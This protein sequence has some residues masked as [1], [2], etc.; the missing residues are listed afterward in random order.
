MSWQA[1][2]LTLTVI[3]T[4]TLTLTLTL[5]LTLTLTLTQHRTLIS[6]QSES[7]VSQAYP[8]TRID[9]V[10]ACP[11]TAARRAADEAAGAQG[12]VAQAQQELERRQ[13]AY[14]AAQQEQQVRTLLL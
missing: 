8:N 5:I 11:P 6:L 13:S 12:T 10:H 9:H 1:L 4:P 14:K 7:M 3:L 2:T